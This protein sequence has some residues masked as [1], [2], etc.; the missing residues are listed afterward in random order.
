MVQINLQS[1]VHI[2]NQQIILILDYTRDKLDDY[3]VKK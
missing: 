1:L 3:F 2:S